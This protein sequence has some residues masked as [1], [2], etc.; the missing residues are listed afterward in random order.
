MPYKAELR[1]IAEA[2]LELVAAFVRYEDAIDAF[3]KAAAKDPEP[4]SQE[5]EFEPIPQ[6]RLR[7]VPA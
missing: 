3:E 4:N 7:T 2:R 1:A 5:L 6:H